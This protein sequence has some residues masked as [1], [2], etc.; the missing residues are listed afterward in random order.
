MAMQRS[1]KHDPAITRIDIVTLDPSSIDFV[2]N[3][4]KSAL[5]LERW[6]CGL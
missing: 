5:K 3:H 1:K 6:L 4:Q 2:L